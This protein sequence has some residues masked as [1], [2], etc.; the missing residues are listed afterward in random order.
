M[1]RYLSQ[2]TADKLEQ[3]LVSIH[4]RQLNKL[5]A[6]FTENDLSL[7]L[8]IS[9]TTSC[10]TVDGSVAHEQSQIQQIMMLMPPGSS[11]R[12]QWHPI[13]KMETLMSD[14]LDH[15]VHQWWSLQTHLLSQLPRKAWNQAWNLARPRSVWIMCDQQTVST[16]PAKIE[17]CTGS[18][19]KIWKLWLN[20][21]NTVPCLDFSLILS[22]KHSTA[23]EGHQVRGEIP[24]L[25]I[26]VSPNQCQGL[27]CCSEAS[28]QNL[29]S[30]CPQ[31]NL[32]G[33]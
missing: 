2:L 11:S 31:S 25:C 6:P 12:E 29:S 8:P 9:C 7:N 33:A 3:P 28:C 30:L 1:F 19:L 20:L 24:S 22:V 17:S 5:S 10:R 14:L 32:W 18:A 13:L 21:S 26:P 15:L 16:K 23:S 27:I 4:E